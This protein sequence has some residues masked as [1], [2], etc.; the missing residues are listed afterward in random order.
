VVTSSGSLALGNYVGSIALG[1]PCKNTTRVG[2][3][4]EVNRSDVT[5]TRTPRSTA[6]VARCATS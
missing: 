1:K 6:V 5:L 3:N 4:Y 2:H